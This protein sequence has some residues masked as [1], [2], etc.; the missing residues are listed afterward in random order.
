MTPKWAVRSEG[1]EACSRAV[2]ARTRRWCGFH[3]AGRKA[4]LTTHFPSLWS[5]EKTENSHLC[6]K[7]LSHQHLGHLSSPHFKKVATSSHSS[8]RRLERTRSA[9]EPPLCSPPPTGSVLCLNTCH[10]FHYGTQV[11]AQRSPF[12]RG[13]TSSSPLPPFSVGFCH[14]SFTHC[15]ASCP[16]LWW[17]E[18]LMEVGSASVLLT[19]HSTSRDTIFELHYLHW[20]ADSCFCIWLLKLTSLLR[21]EDA[22]QCIHSTLCYFGVIIVLTGEKKN[23]T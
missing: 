11:S 4:H 17:T 8:Q 23:P 18:G 14:G 6:L 21:T 22:P 20:S 5:Q 1:Q 10:G 3:A 15:F 13:V 16:S 19:P 2:K 12:E 9:L 7:F